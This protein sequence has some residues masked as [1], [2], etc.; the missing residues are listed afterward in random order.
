MNKQKSNDHLIKGFLLGG[1]IGTIIG[2]LFSPHQGRKNR[3]IIKKSI[4]SLP[5]LSEDLSYNLQLQ[6]KILSKNTLKKWDH[7]VVRLQKAIAAGI[8]ASQ[9][10]AENKH[11]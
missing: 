4:E 9:K 3:Q 6:T 2:L 5:Q 10:E 11:D 1:A 8:S 7:T